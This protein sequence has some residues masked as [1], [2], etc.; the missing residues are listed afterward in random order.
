MQGPFDNSKFV[1]YR[2]NLTKAS[3]SWLYYVIY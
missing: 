2:A 3:K 1:Y